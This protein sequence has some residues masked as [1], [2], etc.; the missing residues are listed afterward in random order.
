MSRAAQV[1]LA[2]LCCLALAEAEIVYQGCWS[3][4]E[5]DLPVRSL[6]FKAAANNFMDPGFCK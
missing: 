3:N 5:K 4:A 6:P 2:C 1:V